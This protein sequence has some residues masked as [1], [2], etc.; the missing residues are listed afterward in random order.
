MG[1][2]PGSSQISQLVCSNLDL[3]AQR[4][5]NEKR[6]LAAEAYLNLSQ[7]LCHGSAFYRARAAEYMRVRGDQSY[8][9]RDLFDAE[10]WYRGALWLGGEAADRARL[11]DTLARLSV[12]SVIQKEDQIGRNYLREAQKLDPFREAVLFA[13]EVFPRRTDFRARLGLIFICICVG[14]FA[15]RRIILL[16]TPSKKRASAAR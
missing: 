5:I 14:L 2:A 11:A 3:G 4:A 8:Y 10:Q 1:S 6:L 9:V 13:S 7:S 15:L 16:F 12:Q